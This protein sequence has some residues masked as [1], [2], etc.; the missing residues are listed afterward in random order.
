MAK[1]RAESMDQ[2]AV[3]T[4]DAAGAPRKLRGSPMASPQP[5]GMLGFAPFRGFIR[6]MSVYVIHLALVC[7]E[8]LCCRAYERPIRIVTI[9]ASS[10]TEITRNQSVRVDLLGGVPLPRSSAFR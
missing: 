8:F 9:T 6:G 2:R 5:G 3:W 4:V 10:R 1:K 7:E